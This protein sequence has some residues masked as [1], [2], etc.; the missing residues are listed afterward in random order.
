MQIYSSMAII[1]TENRMV[2]LS[3]TVD[4][5]RQDKLRSAAISA[6]L[7][8]SELVRYMIDKLEEKLGDVEHPNPRALAELKK[9]C[10]QLA[11]T[12]GTVPKGR[13]P[14]IKKS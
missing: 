14:L 13:K 5:E 1:K 3:L 2:P 6:N 7:P 8:M 9:H 4:L 12:K 10:E 11:I